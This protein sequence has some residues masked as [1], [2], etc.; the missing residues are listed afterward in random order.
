MKK[1]RQ[2]SQILLWFFMAVVICGMITVGIITNLTLRSIEKN[3]PGTLLTELNDLSFV[4]ENLAGVVNAVEKS[5]IQ[6]SSENLNLLKAK[7][8]T[9]Y[10]DIVRL[11][12]SYVYDN[13][14]KASAFHAV[15]APAITDLQVW[16][17]D[18]VSGYGPE[19]KQTATISLLRIQEAYQTARMLTNKSR[20]NA[21][22]IL[23]R[24]RNRLDRFLFNVNLFFVMTIIITFSMVYL[25]V[26]QYV[27][28]RR[29]F[30]AQS[31]LREQRDLLSSLFENVLM[32]ITVSNQEG[33]LLLSNK[34]FKEI[35]GYSMEDIET[36]DDWFPKAYPDPVYREKVMANWKAATSKNRA[37]REFKITCKNGEVKDI[38]FRGTFLKDGRALLTMSDITG[39]KQTERMLKE[40]QKIKVRAKKMES[41]GL[42]AGGVAHDL[43]N[44]LSGIVS[45]PELL[46]MDLPE[47]SNLRKPIQTIQESGQRA[48]AIV[49]DLLT[50][51]R[52]VATSKE[53]MNLNKLIRDYLVSPEF[54][55]LKHFHDAVKIET[56]L[57]DNLFNI[58]GSQTHIRKVV[59][60]LVSNAEEAIDI[61]GTIT[62]STANSYV[63]KPFR[64]YDDFNEGEYVILSVSDDGSGI[65]EDNLERIFEPFY[66][67]KVMGR[68]GTGL[69][70]AVV[71]N[72]VQDH[73]GYIDLKS[74]NNRTT[75]NLYFPITREVVSDR[76]L[77]RP[78]EDYKGNGEKILI[79][80]DIDSQRKIALKMLEKLG[81]SATFVS[82]GEEAV[83]YLKQHEA[84]LIV[85]D[86]IMDPGINGRETYERILKIKPNQ[87]AIIA[88][89]FAETKEVKKAQQLGAGRY[90][91]KPFNLENLGIAVKDELEK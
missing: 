84:D 80:D 30:I 50:V 65:S 85:L 73:K 32:G 34:A 71:W 66:T 3:L 21:Q 22:K 59:M 46:L 81:Y 9:V 1:N 76:K 67:K 89:G 90:I 36:L 7:I 58:Y 54:E 60:N 19:T 20:V 5:T 18:G 24:Q 82:S 38:E 69:G 27:L 29:E 77:H 41:L 91:R 23:E 83:E 42:L 8:H 26:Q 17:T 6:T 61:D 48:A 75:F 31:E 57:D 35:S 45:Y 72:I 87:K 51:A 53:P 15:V 12:E 10:E 39:R 64:G 56:N 70:L 43:N 49:L 63:D 86:M 47:D 88:S 55:K 33:K 78:L 2:F 13:L 4:L 14:V 37:I 25:L 28:Q 16:L 52:G 68:S 11:R 44:I 79:V 74:E 62:I 40:S